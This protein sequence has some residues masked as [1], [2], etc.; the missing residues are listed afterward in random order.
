MQ[1]V[2]S[3]PAGVFA[4]TIHRLHH[5]M[6]FFLFFSYSMAWFLAFFADLT[7]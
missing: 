3:A 1:H 4:D 7:L 2:L 6:A 5:A